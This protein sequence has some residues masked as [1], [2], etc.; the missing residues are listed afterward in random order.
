MNA[1][2][3]FRHTPATGDPSLKIEVLGA[4]TCEDTAIV[5]DRLDTLGVAYRYL[6]VDLDDAALARLQVLNGG[7]RV[8]PTVVVGG[9]AVAE[10]SLERLGELLA[11]AGIGATVPGPV[12][13]HGDVTSWPIPLR[14]RVTDDGSPF[15]LQTL[16]DRRQVCLFL[17]HDPACLACFGYARQLAG[18]RESL[19]AAEGTLVVV[20]AG[21]PDGLA[22]WRHGLASDAVLVAD[23]D[24][25][26]HRA[27][28]AHLGLEA[29]AATLVVLDRFL[30]PRVV[31]S[32]ADAGGLPDPSEVIAWLDY[33]VLECP[34]CS[35]E[36]PWPDPQASHHHPCPDA[37][38]TPQ[39]VDRP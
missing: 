33:L 21:A 37:I 6:D 27:V 19:D 25:D 16:R 2:T 23:P 14:D 24:G 10:P 15:S 31:A 11:A 30:A 17:A 32:A 8:T 9:V 4:A 20:T 29:T 34:E 13:L 26:W 35:G 36:L 39:G 18:R 5:R 12:Q 1:T 28:A 7:H 38:P 3:V 22:D